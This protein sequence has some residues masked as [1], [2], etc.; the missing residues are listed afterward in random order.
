MLADGQGGGAESE[1]DAPRRALAIRR[2]PLAHRAFLDAPPGPLLKSVGMRS[3]APFK[4][5]LLR[6]DW[7]EAQSVPDPDYFTFV[8][9]RGGA[10][11]R[12]SADPRYRVHRGGV[13]LHPRH[14]ADTWSSAGVVERV[15]FY[16]ALPLVEQAAEAAGR[17]DFQPDAIKPFVGG[18]GRTLSATMNAAGQA[19]F[20]AGQRPSRL[21][22]DTWGMLVAQRLLSLDDDRLAAVAPREYGPVAPPTLRRVVDYIEAHLESD[23]SLNELAGV[24]VMS[25]FHFARRF[26]ASIGVAPHAYVMRRRIERARMLL[27]ETDMPIVQIA[28]VC[29]FANQSHLTAMFRRTFGITPRAYR[30]DRTGMTL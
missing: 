14:E 22:L 16:I 10:E 17:R 20:D 11:A 18:R 8:L 5:A 23:L 12:C 7:G 15:H 24:A 26:R 3:A 21:L 1:R 19:L 25:S 6:D 9:H 2:V 13:S 30:I 4:A 27:I 29:G 28:L